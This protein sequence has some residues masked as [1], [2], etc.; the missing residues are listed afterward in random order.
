MPEEK[1]SPTSPDESLELMPE[2]APFESGFNMRTVWAA[3][4]V[5]FVM[6]PGAIYLG[7][8]TGQSMAGAAEWVT[9]IVFIEITKR[10]FGRLKTQEVI[11]MYWIAGGLVQMGG[12]LGSAANLFGGPFG[13]LVWNQYLI[14]SPQAIGLAEHIPKWVVPPL[15]SKALEMRS[16]LHRDWWFLS[17]SPY[18]GPILILV[19][20]MVISNINRV[21]LGYVMFR[22]TSDIER[23]PFPMSYVQAGGATALAETSGKTETWRWRVFSIG[24]FIGVM[25]GV[26]YVVVPTL[27]GIFLTKTVTILPIPF[28]DFTPA[29]REVFPTAIFGLA[30]NL[31]ILLM[32][33]VLPFWVVVGSFT[34]SIVG[35]FVVNPLLYRAGILHSWSPGMG[36]IPT[37]ICNRIDFW[38]SFSIGT[39]VCIALIGF[40][41]SG[42]AIWKRRRERRDELA[43][44]PPEE[45]AAAMARPDLPEG[46]GDLPI[47]TVLS[48]WALSTVASVVL[49]KILVP[50]FPWYVTAFFG[51]VWTPLTSYIAAR[52]IGIT[53]S[54]YGASFPY[55]RE[56]SF[57]LFY[58]G[59]KADIWFAPLPMYN[60]GGM[61]NTFK[62]LELTKTK[63]SSYV[64]LVALNLVVMF[65]CSFLFWTLIWRLAPIPS[66]AYPF[67]QR[68]WP[69]HATFQAM[70][71]KS[72]LPG[73]SNW[74]QDVIRPE[75][76]VVGLLF[77]TVMYLVML[78]TGLPTRFFYGFVFGLAQ[79]PHHTIPT[80]IGA[81]I[82]RR[83]MTRRFGKKPWRAYAPILLAG[84]FCGM[85]LIGMTSI[86]VALI[87]KAT[88]Q[89]VY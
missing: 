42:R 64:K 17:E 5:G 86:A 40:G 54:P 13:G 22:A 18:L 37:G 26:I 27:S 83:Y 32:G 24:S 44:L 55:L 59:G 33:F 52:M 36:T 58:R 29:I 79:W 47:A 19:V 66:G 41:T 12:K 1:T 68:M 53:G 81:I 28:A 10:T 6:L 9:I 69:F 3:L 56:G 35:N 4:F 63:F 84:Y 11:I 80:F 31:G 77:A 89:I 38:L 30:T 46:R 57:Y 2:D 82:G 50:D 67:V 23:L 70:W 87:S 75:Y 76:A 60:A 15:G 71:A 25:W 16:F 43:K 61:A 14:Q 34:A 20:V 62:Q 48:F 49:C 65:V 21:A 7:L 78:F 45:R 51:F 72:T 74:L 88:S 39:S 73:A 85:G 8:V